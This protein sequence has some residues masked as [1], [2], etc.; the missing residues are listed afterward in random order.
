MRSDRN[1][2]FL[3]KKSKN[4]E[5]QRLLSIAHTLTPEEILKA[6]PKPDLQ[7]AMLF[8]KEFGDQNRS[9]TVAEIVADKMAKSSLPSLTPTFEVWQYYGESHPAKCERSGYIDILSGNLFMRDKN[10]IFI[11]HNWCILSPEILKNSKK[12][13]SDKT[14]HDFNALLSEISNLKPR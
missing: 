5:V 3:L 10:R 13:A 7:K 12:I 11:Q 9:A 2:Y 14:H 4:P 6:T 8:V 1:P